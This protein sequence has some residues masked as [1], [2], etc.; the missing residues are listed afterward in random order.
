MTVPAT[1]AMTMGAKAWTAKCLST[2]S[3]AKSAPAIGA[4]KLAETAAATAQPSRSRPVIPSAFIR[5]DT[6]VEI[7]AARC[8]T[9]PSRPEDPPEPSVIIDA[10]AEASPAFT[11]TRPLSSAAP[12]I[13]SATDRTRA[14]GVNQCRISPT[15]SPPATGISRIMTQGRLSAKLWIVRISSTP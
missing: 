15:T 10:T 2:T 8:T 13:T 9:G 5:S 1:E 12:S 4:L 6:Q 14:S 11:S 7:T 3:S